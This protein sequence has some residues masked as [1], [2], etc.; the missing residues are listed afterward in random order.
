[1]AFPH[2][3]IAARLHQGDAATVTEEVGAALEDVVAWTLCSLPGIRILQRDFTNRG[4]SM[5]LDLF[6]FNKHGQSPLDF[7][8]S[9]L[10]VECKNWTAPVGSATVRDFIGKLHSTHQEVGILVAANGVTGD[11]ADQTSANDVI[12]EAFDRDNIK[13]IV[14]T[15]EDIEALRS[16]RDIV[17]LLEQKYGRACLRSTSVA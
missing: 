7:L 13:L 5:E 16:H 1:M 15:R 12:R 4:N 6:L 17:L 3:K 14:L 10:I 8:P 11:A 2:R 9:F